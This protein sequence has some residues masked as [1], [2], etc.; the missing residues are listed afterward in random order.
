MPLA[1]PRIRPPRI[2]GAP[3]VR[4]ARVPL[5]SLRQ[6]DRAVDQFG[7]GPWAKDLNDAIK[8]YIGEVYRF[9]HIDPMLQ[10]S[11]FFGAGAGTIPELVVFGFLLRQGYQYNHTGPRGFRFQGDEIGGRQ[12]AGGAVVDIEVFTGTRR[13]AVRVNSIFH[14]ANDPFGGGKAVWAN[15]EQRIRLMGSHRFDVVMDVS[16]NR[17]LELG[18][19]EAIEADLRRILVA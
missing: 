8:S 3:R 17:E 18:P 2:P 11:G 4:I 10:P 16:Q 12:T 5:P 7:L 9:F 13:V 1:P 6:Q 14:Q 19:A 15:E